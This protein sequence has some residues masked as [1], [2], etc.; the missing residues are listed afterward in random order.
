LTW[1]RFLSPRPFSGQAPFCQPSF[2][3]REI[4]DQSPSLSPQFPF[5]KSNFLIPQRSLAKTSSLLQGS[6]LSGPGV[7]GFSGEGL[8]FELWGDFG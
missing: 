5:V 4:F 6:F 3:A 2:L 1:I 7:F 8:K